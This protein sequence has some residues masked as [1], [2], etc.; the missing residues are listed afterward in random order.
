MHGYDNGKFGAN[1]LLTRS[2]FAQIIYNKQGKP[3]V[4][5]GTFTDI[6]DGQWYANA[7]N[8]AA[9]KGIVAGIGNNMFAP[10]NPITR[11]QLATMLW[12][13]EECPEPKKSE[14]DFKDAGT[15]SRYAWKAILWANENGII[16]GKGNGTLDPKGKATRAETAQMLMNYLDR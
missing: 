3:V 14:L 9:G 12:R 2:E 5:G 16:S 10:N 7:V 11:E 1:D 6:K 13:Y 15:I 8:W 4:S